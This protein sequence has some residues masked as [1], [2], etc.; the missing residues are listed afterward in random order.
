[1]IA[2]AIAEISG[3]RLL[4]L[5][6]FDVLDGKGREDAIYWLDGLAQDSAID[7]AL[8]FGTLKALPAGLPETITPVWIEG[9]VV[10]EIR[11]A[12]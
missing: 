12:A 1:M 11:E 8:I 4:V 10:G 5:D 7:T 9:G 3:L 6:R 2:A